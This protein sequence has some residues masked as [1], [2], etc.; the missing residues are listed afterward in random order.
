MIGSTKIKK[1]LRDSFSS[2]KLKL[3]KFKK[4]STKKKLYTSDQGFPNKIAPFSEIK[5]KI[6]PMILYSIFLLRPPFLAKNIVLEI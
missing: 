3:F 1:I 5:K 6:T 4:C 2:L